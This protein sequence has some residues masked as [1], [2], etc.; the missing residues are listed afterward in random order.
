[1]PSG[2]R[3]SLTAL[4]NPEP[5]CAVC[6]RVLN[7]HLQVGTDLSVLQARRRLHPLYE[8]TVPLLTRCWLKTSDCITNTA[9]ICP[10]L[11]TE[12]PNAQIAHSAMRRCNSVNCA[13][14][15]SEGASVIRS[16]ALC[17]LGKAITSLMLFSSAR[18]ITN[19]SMPGA[20]PP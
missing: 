9:G 11:S 17:V 15:T 5:R 2:R 13:S 19:R 3:V 14:S 12:S 7:L 4:D 1:M 10:Y 8:S 20:M 6:T 18:S 16:D